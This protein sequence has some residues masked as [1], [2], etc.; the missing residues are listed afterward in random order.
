MFGYTRGN[1][2]YL[3]TS[4]VVIQPCA[5]PMYEELEN[6]TPERFGKSLFGVSIPITWG[7]RQIFAVS[8]FL[9]GVSS[10][11][12]V[13]AYVSFG[14]ATPGDI[15]DTFPSGEWYTLLNR[16]AMALVCVASY[17]LFL[18]PIIAPVRLHGK[19]TIT[20]NICTALVVLILAV[21]AMFLKNLGRVFAMSGAI[22]ILFFVGIFPSVIGYSL[23]NENPSLM[24]LLFLVG[25][26]PS[27][28]GIL[29]TTNDA[30]DLVTSCVW[31]A[32][33]PMRPSHPHNHAK[34]IRQKHSQPMTLHL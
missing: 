20:S 12:S 3:S 4:A 32:H 18:R 16:A 5:L 25:C 10:L 26:V 2:T 34:S 13:V 9:W 23:G 28:L 15:L 8:I 31:K 30:E 11:F 24:I 27:I 22:S 7:K 29:H 19:R 21:F 17:P 6:R 33:P 14:A 1:I